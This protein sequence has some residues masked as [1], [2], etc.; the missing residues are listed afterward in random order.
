[1]AVRRFHRLRRLQRYFKIL[2]ILLSAYSIPFSLYTLSKLQKNLTV[3]N[4]VQLF[5]ETPQMRNTSE[6]I[7]TVSA[8]DGFLNVYIWR[9]LCGDSVKNLKKLP[10][11][12]QHPDE[13]KLTDVLHIEDNTED[14][15]QRIF[16]FIQ[17]PRSDSYLFGIASDD[18]SELWLSPSENPRDKQL[19]A[20]V[21]KQH[22]IAWTKVGQL[23]KYSDQ[24]SKTAVKLER[25]KK[26][27]IEILHT[28]IKGAGFVQVFW[29]KSDD[30]NFNVISADHLSTY[31]KASA[32][33]RKEAIPTVLSRRFQ[34]SLQIKSADG[35]K[36][37]YYKFYSLPFI[38]IEKFLPSCDYKTT[39]QKVTR[40]QGIKWVVNSHV[41]P[42]DDTTMGLDDGDI[43]TRPNFRVDDELIESVVDKIMSS[44]E[45]L[46]SEY[47]L[48][49]IHQVKLKPGLLY[50]DRYLVDLELGIKHKGASYRFSEHVYQ[51]KGSSRLC[52][53]N[54]LTWNKAAIVYFIL[55]VKDQGEWVYHFINEITAASLLTKDE[56]FHIIVVDF[57]SQDISISQAFDTDLLRNRHTIIN[58]TGKF[59]K[60]LALNK[61]VE[62]VPSEHDLL[63]LFDLHI[64]VPAD[65][66]DSIRK[67]T[68]KGHIVFC[69]QVGRLNCGSSSVDH[70][71][72]WELDGYGLVGVYKADWE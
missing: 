4:G 48:K 60:T 28:Q 61:A 46:N 44:I 54:G 8:L 30:F 1:M 36:H 55:P 51:K 31:S 2:L 71:G 11:F 49:R 7:A 35:T 25:G 66:M 38:P 64:D 57:E 26:Y 59:Y 37:D 13:E 22:S 29:R 56:N 50:G 33:V 24:V 52:S 45:R 72:Y 20:S 32:V 43:W 65:I 62:H 42:E 70:K 19:I 63:F 67:N 10:F 12:P 6:S 14:Y 39:R 17:P 23:D 58:M 53:P 47:Y 5:N 27:Y 69:P 3:S 68:I 41:F 34:N 18:S 9:K 15:G 16:G 40:F 21:F